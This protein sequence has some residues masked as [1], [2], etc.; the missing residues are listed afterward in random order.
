MGVIFIVGAFG[1]Y[2]L[3]F[4]CCFDDKMPKT[5]IRYIFL[6]IRPEFTQIKSSFNKMLTYLGKLVSKKEIQI[7]NFGV[8]AKKKRT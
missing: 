2:F 4:S 8:I 1:T 6:G 5:S 7:V 3:M